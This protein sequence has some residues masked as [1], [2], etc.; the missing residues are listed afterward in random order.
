MKK[1]TAIVVATIILA[2]GGCAHTG[3]RHLNVWPL[4]YYS[5][6]AQQETKTLSILTPIIYYHKG[7]EG[8]EFSVRPVFSMIRDD[9]SDSTVI[10]ILYP[11]IKYKKN[12]IDE[13]FRVFPIIKDETADVFPNKTRTAHD[14]FPLFWG[15]SEEGKSYGGLFPVYGTVKDRF[16][17]DDIFFL[18]WPVYSRTVEDSMISHTVLWPVFKKTTGDE[19]GGMQVFPLWGHEEI[20]GKSYR[21]FYLFPLVTLQGKYL[22]TDTPMRDT[23]IIPFYVSRRTPNSRSTSYLWPF[24]T[25]STSEDTNYRK[26]NAPW[27]LVSFAKSDTLSLIQFAP[28]YRK[29]VRSEKDS[30]DVSSYILYP[31]YSWGRFTSPSETEE[32][33]RFMLIDKY[34]RTTYSDGSDELQVYFFPLYDR[35]KLKTGEDSTVL[36][37]PLP[38]HDDGFKR[39]YLPLFE[40]FRHEISA[41]GADR[42]TILHHLLIREVKDGVETLDAP[43]YLRRQPQ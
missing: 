5:E 34:V 22:D 1:S 43:F 4:V 24:F 12:G 27:P 18:L 31:I 16:G 2:C 3:A 23:I 42:L 11:L 9:S 41:D 25:I 6:D 30:L 29:R 39:N 21:T 10:D 8:R 20:T 38:L 37:Y 26:I 32:T 40:I 36:F 13:K 33:Y 15:R 14:Y 19:G 28:F 35:R 7:K 17:K